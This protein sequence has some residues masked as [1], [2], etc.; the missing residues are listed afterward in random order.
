MIKP[1][2]DFTTDF[3]HIKMKSYYL[4][5]ETYTILGGKCR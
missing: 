3:F 4:S 2:V 1:V 5:I